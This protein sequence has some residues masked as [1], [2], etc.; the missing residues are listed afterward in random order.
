MRTVHRF[1]VQPAIPERLS[2]LHELAYNLRWTW[3]HDTIELF[4]RLD[5]D[6]WQEC[7]HNPVLLLNRV[8]QARFQE[9]LEDDAFLAHQDRV[10]ASLKAYLSDPGWFPKQHP[11]GTDLTIGYFSMEFGLTECL[12]IYSGGLGALAGDHLKSAS[13]LDLP[14][15]A[16]GLLYQKGYF[17]QYLNSDGWQLEEYHTNDF[18]TLPIQPVTREDGKVLEV[19]VDLAGRRVS[20]RVWRAQ[21]GRIPLYLLDTNLAQNHP[22]DQDVTDEL[23]GGGPEERIRQE[24]VL[25]IGGIRALEAMGIKPRVCHMNEGHS[26]FLSLER[27][28]R[29]LQ[30]SSLDYQSARQVASAGTVF[31]THTPVPAGFD[32]FSKEL[33]EKYFA[34]YVGELGLTMDQFMAKGRAVPSDQAEPFNVAVLSL[35][36]A[37]RRNAVSA[38]H[39]RVTAHMMRAGWP[40]LPDEDMPI[41]Y[42]TNGV[43]MRGWVAAD[44]AQ[45]FDRYLGPRWRE[46][47]ADPAV[48]SRI[49][50][51]PDEELWRTHTRQRERLVAFVRS[52][53]ETQLKR[54]NASPRELE[55]AREALRADALTIGFARRFATYKRATLVLREVDRLKT[56]LL[57]ERHPV[58]FVFAGKAH[59]RD[60]AGKEFIREIVR[61]AKQQGVQ[62]RLVFLE[63]YALDIARAL[64]QGADVWLNTPRRP[65][66]A[67]GTSGMK[68]VVN[69]GLN[70]SVLDGWWD[71]GYSSEVGWAIGT[72]EEYEDTD[73]QD[74]VESRSLYSLMEEQIVPLFYDR[75]SDGIPRGWLAM[76]KASMARL[77]PQFS[78][79]R[80]VREYTERFY[81]PAGAHFG[82]LAAEDYAKAREIALWKDHVRTEWPG[83]ELVAVADSDGETVTVGASLSFHAKVRLGG[84]SPDDVAVEAYHGLL[85]GEGSL[86]S[87]RTVRLEWASE[88]GGVHSYEGHVVC[89]RSGMHGYSVR[90]LPSHDDVLIPNE[91]Q[92]VRWE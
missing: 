62:H 59:P 40:D 91:L 60:D 26:A 2:C 75:G 77:T 81:L 43:H 88:E 83:V 58:Q 14:L 36:H 7:R 50:R 24:I 3:D 31:T 20:V 1:H 76:M 71:E 48:W 79:A 69:G 47:P 78:A 45:L 80:M 44:L 86:V 57:D 39:R 25:G 53:L 10:C 11:E 49:D 54:R 52:N 63:D 30:E 87:G 65:L 16:V 55:A 61:F 67:S 28:R 32:L 89:E 70:L 51:V 35:R 42:V 74:R 29:L 19:S 72:G 68:V 15:V 34:N 37:Y 64:V 92:L 22:A 6:M 8:S 66:E 17:S 38:L 46:D 90:V 21:V 5:A 84:L 73:Y 33:V 4:L 12:P 82:R 27:V 9:V 23:Y 56:L 13:D 85:D 18:S 41:E